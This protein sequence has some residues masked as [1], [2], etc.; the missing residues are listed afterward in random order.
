MFWWWKGYFCV[1]NINGNS[2]FNW[3]FMPVIGLW[4]ISKHISNDSCWWISLQLC[5][6]VQYIHFVWHSKF[7][8]I[9]LCCLDCHLIS[10]AMLK[11]PIKRT[12]SRWTFIIFSGAA[13]RSYLLNHGRGSFFALEK[14]TNNSVVRWGLSLC[15]FFIVFYAENNYPVILCNF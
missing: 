6:Y 2:E 5:S 11:M 8:Y 1:K 15:N 9:N 12:C 4:S 3:C 13:I 14:L 10:F 7:L